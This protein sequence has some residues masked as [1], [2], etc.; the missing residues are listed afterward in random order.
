MCQ[1]PCAGGSFLARRWPDRAPVQRGV[2]HVHADLL[3]QVGGDVALRL[4]DGDI[5][6]HQQHDRLALVARGGQQLPCRRM[7]ALALQRLAADL[8]IQ[9]RARREEA[10]QGLP[11]RFVVADHG[12]HVVGLVQR[13]LHRAARADVVERRIQMID[14]ERTDIAERI[15][16][17]DRQ[18]GGFA[19]QRHQVGQR[20]FPPIDLAALQRRRGGSGIRQ[21]VPLDPVEGDPLAAGQPARRLGA[22][23]VAG[24]FLERRHRAGH[25]LVALEAHR[26]GADILVDLLERIGLRDALRHDEQHRRA[27]LAQ[28]EQQLRVRLVQPEA[29]GPIIDRLQRVEPLADR[30]PHRRIAH[31]PAGDAGDHVAR[32]HRRAVVERQPRAQ[33]EGPGLEVGA[34]RMPLDHLRLRFK[35]VIDP[36]QRVPDQQGAVAHDI[37]RGPDRIEVGQIG[38]R[39][40]PQHLVARRA[41]QPWHGKSAR[42]GKR[43]RGG[44]LQ[45]IPTL[46]RLFSPCSKWFCAPAPSPAPSEGFQG[47]ALG[48]VQGRSPWP[49]FHPRHAVR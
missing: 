33:P 2:L 26:A 5:G 1:P 15:G 44:G 23:D 20:G 10:G 13:D 7:V 37:L 25:P 9:R 29:E 32:Q 3:Q 28:R 43:T 8:G 11:Q 24:E 17:I 4:G 40:K 6:R 38:L 27:A 31:H 30:Q 46:H 34:D 14:T 36:V 41:R 42:R 49:G 35:P 21:D 18:S 48:G 47:R 12:M 45:K 16:D 19:Q 39:H 22:R